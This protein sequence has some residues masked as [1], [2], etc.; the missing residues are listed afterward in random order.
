ME[1]Q[2]T[3]KE[4]L[5]LQQINLQVVASEYLTVFLL[6]MPILVGWPHVLFHLDMSSF[7]GHKIGSGDIL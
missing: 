7:F 1:T 6:E 2:Q 3:E 5:K 4:A